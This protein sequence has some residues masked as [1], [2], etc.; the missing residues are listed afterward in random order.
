MSE[1]L[2][3]SVNIENW[4]NTP[5]VNKR[6]GTEEDVKNGIA[7]FYIKDPE[8]I[9]AQPLNLELPKCAIYK[10]ENNK[11]IPIIIIQAEET[12]GRSYIGY[13]NLDNGNGICSIDEIEILEKPNELFLK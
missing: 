8:K 7:V 1:E 9:S 5:C 6:L 10:D 4:K 3:N 12:D 13:R 2:W 11:E